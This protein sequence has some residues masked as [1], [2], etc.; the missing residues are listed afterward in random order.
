MKYVLSKCTSVI[1][2]RTTGSA[3]ART[4]EVGRELFYASINFVHGTGPV[5]LESVIMFFVCSQF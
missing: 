2:Q 1:L 4:E 5:S 3:L